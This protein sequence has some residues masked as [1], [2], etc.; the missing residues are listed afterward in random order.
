MKP[1]GRGRRSGKGK[2]AGRGHKGQGARGTK[3]VP[4]FEGGQNPIYLRFPKIK[5]PTTSL[6]YEHVTIEKLLYAI[7]RDWIDP[8]NLITIRDMVKCGIIS[9]PKQGVKLFEDVKFLNKK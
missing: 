5:I 4:R 2:T 9:K 1:L 8:S 3:R 6:F 7:K